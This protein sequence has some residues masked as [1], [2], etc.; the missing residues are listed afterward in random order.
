MKASHVN[1][2]EIDN[3]VKWLEDTYGD[4]IG[5][6]KVSRGKVHDYLGM[7]LD[8]SSERKVKINMVEY[9]KKIILDFPEQDIST[10]KTPAANHLFEVREDA[11][12]LSED[13]AIIFHNMVARA[14]LR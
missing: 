14:L 11:T 2:N 7:R 4:E 8:F 1:N 3:F 6:V 13:K 5:K 10:A 12:K 9:V